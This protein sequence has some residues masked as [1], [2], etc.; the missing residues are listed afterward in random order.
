VCTYVKIVSILCMRMWQ[1]FGCARYIHVH[2]YT[3]IHL[4]TYRDKLLSA[5]DRKAFL[6]V[7]EQGLSDVDDGDLLVRAAF[8]D[9][10]MGKMKMAAVQVHQYVCMYVC[11]YES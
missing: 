11:M 8:E 6:N 4:H 1:H 9:I 5:P 10:K 2:K 3:Q 7:L